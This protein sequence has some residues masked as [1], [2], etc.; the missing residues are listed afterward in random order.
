VPLLQRYVH[1]S[2]TQRA[3]RVV[4][5][6]KPYIHG[7][8]L[9]VGCWNG[10]V[11]RDLTDDIVGID[12]APPPE[13]VIPVTVFDGKHI[14]FADGE[15]DTVLCC[16][17][18]HHAADQDTLLDEM[19]RVGKRLVIMEDRYDNVL[20]RLSVTALHA[21]GSRVVGMPYLIHGFR[22]ISG[23][24]ELFARHHVRID[25]CDCHPGIQPLWPGLRHYVFVLQPM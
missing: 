2:D 1:W 5:I 13:P 7:R 23:W 3:A 9:D 4:K 10:L 15:F 6:L 16:T 24:R 21:I 18:L 19:R 20:D 12:V 17:A 25:A 8:T 14:P 22:H 11:A